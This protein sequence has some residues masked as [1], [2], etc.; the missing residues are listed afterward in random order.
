MRGPWPRLGCC[1]EEINNYFDTEILKF[2]RN[3]GWLKNMESIHK[4]LSLEQLTAPR[5]TP[6]SWLRYS[7]FSARSTGWLAWAKLKIL[8]NSSHVLLWYTW[9][10]GAFAFTQTALFAQIGHSNDKCSSSLEVE[11]WNEDETHPVQQS[12]TTVLMNSRTQ[13]ILCCIVANLLP[14]D[15][16]ARLYARRAL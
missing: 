4:S 2:E 13:K 9:S 7:K 14:T 15:A 1:A 16:A 8:F 6:D 3:T 5:H 12:P 10:A 11:C